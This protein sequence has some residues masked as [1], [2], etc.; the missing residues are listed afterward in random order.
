MLM[1]E[2]QIIDLIS[3]GEGIRVEFKES[4]NKLNK[5]IFESVCAFLNRDGGHLF[6]GVADDGTILGID[7]DSVGK[8][9]DNFVSLM[10]NPD[11]INP[12]F[13]LL[14]QDIK[15]QDK[16]ILYVLIPTSSQVHR[17]NGKIYDRNEDG[18]FDISNSTGLVAGLYL[19]KHSIY[20]ENMV[21]PAVKRSD[22]RD[23]VFEK[24]KKMAS[25]QKEDH[26][27]ENMDHLELL[28]S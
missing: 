8:I 15:I 28:K 21:F 26:P 24:V 2:K 10:N 23:D 11:K 5:D 13:Y 25:G 1:Q 16:T 14:V 12:T 27:W 6:L 18:D 19:R 17:C 9:K 22:L 3:K 20:S 7:D 4:K